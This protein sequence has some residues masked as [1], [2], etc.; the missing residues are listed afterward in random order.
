MT[1]G[2]YARRAGHGAVALLGLVTLAGLGACG[3]EAEHQAEPA[4]E[5]RIAAERL[6]VVRDTTVA[7]IIDASGVAR[8]Y[9]EATL[10][11]KLMG[12][13]ETVT[14]H[15][16]DVVSAGQP[17]VR[18][19]ARDLVAKQ[20]QVEA[21]IAEARVMVRDAR[22]QADRMR[23]LYEDDAAPRAQLD[24]AETGLARAEAGVDA[25]LAAAGELEATL[26]YSVIRAPFGG[27]VTR[28]YVDPGAFA[29]PGAPLIEIQDG[30]RLRITASSPPA[31]VRR[32]SRGDTVDATIEGE[33]VRAVVEG[34]VPAAGGNLYT[35]NA[36][37][38]NDPARFLPGSAARISLRQGE[39]SG[40]VI[41]AMAV[42]R[43]GDLTGVHVQQ[44]DGSVELR[45]IRLGR[46]VGEALVEVISGLESGE[47]IVLD[48][49]ATRAGSEAAPVP[50][51]AS[52]EVEA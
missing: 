16:G 46:T 28:R 47:R 25:A 42:V 37:L 24:A 9:A 35:V 2:G 33:R 32:L 45:W 8:P 19:D 48:E 26:T 40:L 18:I 39:R 43:E 22:R 36:L 49:I 12:T 11:T 23:A 3:G 44:P 20:A 51:A 5:L 14:V 10:S 50:D 15:E 38:D 41:P 31:A 6:Y 13:V 1:A 29:A 30:S 21:R 4:A 7:A 27:T 17:L 34:V 52:A